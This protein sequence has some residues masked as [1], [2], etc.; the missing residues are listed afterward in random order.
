MTPSTV[1]RPAAERPARSRSSLT[2]EQ[3]LLVQSTLLWTPQALSRWAAVVALSA[4][5]LLGSWYAI[6]GEATWNDQ[7]PAM[8]VGIACAVVANAAGIFLLLAGR[9]AIGIRRVVLLGEPPVLAVPYPRDPMD[10]PAPTGEVAA[11]VGGAGLKHFHR[12]DC[13]LAAAKSFPSASRSEHQSDGRIPCG[14]C[15]P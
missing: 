12:A 13:T 6:G 5:G 15:R 4:I 2:R 10:L 8:N 7:V 3:A 9:R 1:R 11:L 14:V